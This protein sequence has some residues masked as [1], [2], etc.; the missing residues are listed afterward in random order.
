M[1]IRRNIILF[2]LN[3]LFG[4]L[5]PLSAL[6]VVYFQQIT[7]SWALALGVYSIM[8]ITQS[9]AEIPTGIIS[10]RIGRQKTMITSAAL[11]FIAFI[12]IAVAGNLN[13]GSLLILGAIFLGLSYAFS[14]GTDDAF[15]YETVQELRKE[16]KY[17]IIYSRMKAFSQI[18]HATGALI[19]AVVTYFYSL[20]ILA[21]LSAV[22]GLIQTIIC[23]WFIEPKNHTR[24]DVT[25]WKHFIVALKEFLKNKKL[26]YMGMIQIFH[27]GIDFTSHRMESAY[28]N[29]LIPTWAV[30]IIRVIKQFFGTISFSVAPYFRKFGFYRML[31]TSSI[32]IFFIK[33]TGLILNNFVSPF[34]YSGVNLFY[35][36]LTTAEST[37]LQKELSQKQR[38][39]MGSIV[40][41]LGGI[42]S[43]VFFYLIGLIADISSIY[44]AMILLVFC[45]LLISGGH[46]LL[47]KRYK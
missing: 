33:T 26:Q 12:I 2:K 1:K 32:S 13:R 30:N 25:S 45:G 18:G 41:L 42:I 9:I 4:G 36:T 22:C 47:L 34:V 20:N 3:S 5:W 17:D 15:I 8:G 35:G 31:V 43:A 46:Y 10:D 7:D 6:A 11:F 16:D 24:E 19:A 44:F 38:A 14:S 27:R 37:L 28:F 23:F 39:T 29:L 21:W 40:S